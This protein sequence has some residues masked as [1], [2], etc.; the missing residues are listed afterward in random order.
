MDNRQVGSFPERE[1]WPGLGG[2]NFSLVLGILNLKCSCYIIEGR[3]LEA[4]R[5]RILEFRAEVWPGDPQ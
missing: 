4:D 2:E 3:Q 5:V 1:Q